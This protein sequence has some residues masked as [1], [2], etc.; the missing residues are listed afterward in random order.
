MSAQMGADRL[1]DCSALMPTWPVTN[2][3]PASTEWGKAFLAPA[4]LVT[5]SHTK[6]LHA[7]RLVQR[8][9]MNRLNQVWPLPK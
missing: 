4:L 2:T 8:E 6:T 1:P 3:H 5:Q 7:L 9:A